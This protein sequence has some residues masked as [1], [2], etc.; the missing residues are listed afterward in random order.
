MEQYLKLIVKEIA[1]KNIQAQLMMK[2]N[3]LLIILLI[4]TELLNN[5]DVFHLFHASVI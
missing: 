5:Q 3:Q 1:T 4:L 2:C